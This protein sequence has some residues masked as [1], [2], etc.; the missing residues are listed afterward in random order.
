LNK[1]SH[2][3]PASVDPPHVLAKTGFCNL[4]ATNA[5]NW[6]ETALEQQKCC[7]ALASSIG[8]QVP[9][10]N[11][12]RDLG[13]GFGGARPGWKALLECIERGDVMYLFATERSRLTRNAAEV[14]P[15]VKLLKTT[16]L[17]L[18]TRDVDTHLDSWEIMFNISFP[19]GPAEATGARS[20]S[21]GARIR[22]SLQARGMREARVGNVK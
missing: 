2:T 3:T 19:I 12:Y 17:N 7:V 6:E 16:G 11:V 14:L 13:S 1:P 8:V 22:R 5:S 20:R 9:H 10:E 4:R 21:H 18:L 15:F